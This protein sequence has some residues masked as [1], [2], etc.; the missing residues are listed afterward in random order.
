MGIGSV[1]EAEMGAFAKLASGVILLFTPT[2]AIAQDID[3]TKIKPVIIGAAEELRTASMKELTI[4]EYRNI[5]GISCYALTELSRDE[6]FA[7]LLREY[8]TRQYDDKLAS[9]ITDIF[10]NF[11]SLLEFLVIER[12]VLLNAGLSEDAV[13]HLLG[14]IVRVRLEAAGF[15]LD[16]EALLTDLRRLAEQACSANETVSDSVERSEMW[17][18]IARIGTFTSGAAAAVADAV[19]LYLAKIPQAAAYASGVAGSVIMGGAAMMP[20]C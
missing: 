17:C 10:L 3:L 7:S 16:A 4:D 11:R 2:A 1:R 15:T 5:M 12:D 19:A 13:D 14:Q 20:Q 18:N 8:G 9:E 6:N